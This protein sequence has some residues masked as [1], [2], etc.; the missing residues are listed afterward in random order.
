[1]ELRIQVKWKGVDPRFFD[2]QDA[3]A[4]VEEIVKVAREYEEN[5]EVVAVRIINEREEVVWP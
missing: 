2:T 4:D 1:M 5:P 3:G